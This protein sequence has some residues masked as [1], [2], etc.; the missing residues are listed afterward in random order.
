MLRK[1]L[2]LKANTR[3][4][5]PIEP[6]HKYYRLLLEQQQANVNAERSHFVGRWGDCTAALAISVDDY[7]FSLGAC[8]ASNI[9]LR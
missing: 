1:L 7:R 4:T 2:C 5:M 6:V 3:D 9:V 8:G